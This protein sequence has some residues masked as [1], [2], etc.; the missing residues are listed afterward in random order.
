MDRGRPIAKEQKTYYKPLKCDDG[1]SHSDVPERPKSSRGRPRP[2]Q[3]SSTYEQSPSPTRRQR[4]KSA[5]GRSRIANRLQPSHQ[6]TEHVVQTDV[7]VLDQSN[8]SSHNPL[9]TSSN[10][11]SYSYTSPLN[12]TH[13]PQDPTSSQLTFQSSTQDFEYYGERQTVNSPDTYVDYLFCPDNIFKLLCI[14][15]L[16]L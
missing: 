9:S 6:H 15:I 1:P 14:I 3:D 13:V 12:P 7:L 10:T 2:E 5:K 11:Q 4:P 8:V 16:H